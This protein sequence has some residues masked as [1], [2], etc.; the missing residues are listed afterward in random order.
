MDVIAGQNWSCHLTES[1][2]VEPWGVLAALSNNKP[3]L[4]YKST[5]LDASNFS[6][7]ITFKYM[8]FKSY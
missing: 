1:G 8:A 2:S 3:C 7:D 6:C 4:S 5:R